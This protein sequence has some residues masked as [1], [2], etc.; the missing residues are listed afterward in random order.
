MVGTL[1]PDGRTPVLLSAHAEGLVATDAAAILTYLDRRPATEVADV[2]STLLRTRRLRRH[3]AVIRAAHVDELR[4][5][6]TALAV[7]DDHP[8]I[9]RATAPAAQAGNPRVAFVFPGQGSQWP[10]MGAAA[11]DRLPEYRAEVDACAAVFSAAGAASPLDYLLAEPGARTNDFSQ[12]QIQGAQF[13]HGVALARVWR[14]AGVLPDVTVGHSLGEIGAAYVAGAI[15]LPV[16][17][18]VVIARATLLDRLTGPYRVAVLGITE[19]EAR[20]VIAHTP[21]WLELSVVNSKSSVAVSGDGDA[22][23][24]AVRTVS[25]HGSFAKPIE[26]WFPAHTTALDPMRS[27]LDDLLPG[28]EF[29]DTPIQFIG[30]A[31]ADVVPPGTPFGDYWYGNLRSTVRFDRAVAAA[32]DR[33]ART[34]VEMSAHPALLFA[35][36]DVLDD[37]PDVAEGTVTMVG[38]GRRDED[39]TDCL[40]ANIAAVA[41]ADVSHRWTVPID[42]SRKPLRDFPFAPMRADRHWATPE[43]LPPIAGITVAVEQWQPVPAATV[44]AVR[45]V[46][47]LDAGG[48]QPLAGALRTAV[49]RA[50]GVRQAHLVAADV[51]VVVA[52]H[53]AQDDA[54]AA[55]G[56][57]ADRWERGLLSYVDAVTPTHRDVWLVTVGAERVGAADPAPLPFPAAL[58]S[59]HR[60]IGLEYP[61]HWFRHLDLADDHDVSADALATALLG[62]GDVVA[63]RNVG[64]APVAHQ[65]STRDAPAAPSWSADSGVLDE[66][67]ITGG[68]GAIG[69]HY[70]RALAECGARRIVL[71]SRGG[72]D[73]AVLRRLT[74]THGTEILAPPCD[75]TDRAGLAAT[76]AE[77]GGDGATL[78][79]H[80]AGAAVI[81]SHRDLTTAGVRDTFGAKVAGLGHLVDEWPLRADARILLCSSVSGLWGG[82]GHAAYSAANRLLDV[83]AVHLRARGRHCTAVRW[84]LWQDTGIIDA[85][86]IAR[87]QRSGLLAMSP[88]RAVEESLRDHA[89]DP[90]VFSA[91][92]NRLRAFLGHADTAAAA[93]PSAEGAD[94]PGGL[95]ATDTMRLALGSV[96]SLADAGGIDLDASLLDLGVDSLLALDLRK[97]LKK[98]TGRTVPL[99]TILGGATAAE[100]IEHLNRPDQKALIRD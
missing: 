49:D 24:A 37:L 25:E 85:D 14:S 82:R 97:K 68:G 74:T 28:G 16:A 36:G 35:M 91:D 100:L 78:V 45:R 54:V 1:L 44:G 19:D 23:A 51:L 43:P 12:I 64:S 27:E 2:A 87:V 48:D 26:M 50:D 41:A 59:M 61:D 56:D 55:A 62:D 84:G 52:D 42:G 22:V 93:A 92:P 46:A 69:L 70:A 53:V 10:S 60:S 73:T 38:S 96:L 71:L 99:A 40:S 88:D 47:V 6:L 30:S 75:V 21:G 83:M 8:L 77:F 76:A 57:L 58:A 98:A 11:Y 66:V 90:L 7:G 79:V 63:I 32:V 95:D 81:A 34:F 94:V 5:G 65:R 31:T 80:A 4:A 17:V 18:G 89:D 20:D 86:E 33:G 13:V 3:R 72:A 67:V 39:V 15:T 9:T 29:L